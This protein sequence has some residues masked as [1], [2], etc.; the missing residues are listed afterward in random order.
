MLFVKRKNNNKNM[1]P[2]LVGHAARRGHVVAP[3]GQAVLLRVLLLST[4]SRN[5]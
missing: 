1:L 2:S 3:V 4:C 5:S